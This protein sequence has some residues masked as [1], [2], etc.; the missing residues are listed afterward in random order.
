MSSKSGALGPLWMVLVLILVLV[1]PVQAQPGARQD[2]TLNLVAGSV[3]VFQS[4]RDGNWELYSAN[5][6]GSNLTR[7]TNQNAADTYPRFNHGATR[8]A[9]A[10]RGVANPDIFLVNPDGTGVTQLTTN[11]ADDIMPA[12]TFDGQQ[13]AF[14]SKRNDDYEVYK[15][16]NDGANQ[17][18]LTQ[19]PG[20]DIWPSWSPDATRLVFASNR[21]GD[22]RIWVMN[23][24]GSGQTQLSNQAK[25]NRPAWSPDGAQVA[26]DADG[27][28]DGFQEVWLMN[29]D[30]SNQ[31]QLY[32]PGAGADAQ[33]SGWSPDSY[34]VAYTRVEYQGGNPSAAYL[35]AV[36]VSSGTTVRLVS[37]NQDW[38]MDWQTTDLIPPTSSVD[39]L[40]AV[41]T[42]PFTVGWSMFDT[43][44]AGLRNCD[45]QVKDGAAGAWT[46]WL[47]QATG[48]SSSYPGVGGHTYYFRSRC[49]DN[50]FNLEQY[51]ADAQAVTTV[52]KSAPTSK[53]A[54][55]PAYYR[56]NQ[57]PV[58][59][60]GVDL[61]NSG[62]KS[63]DVQVKEDAG[64]WTNW[65]VGTTETTATYTGTPGH[66]YSFRGRATDNAF[67]VEEWP[68]NP[69]GDT[70][71]TLYAWSIAGNAF[72][73]RDTPLDGVTAGTDPAAFQSRP[74]DDAG[75]Y[76]SYVETVTAA[77]TVT[78]DKAGYG[79]LP[80][81]ELDANQDA[82]MDVILPPADN[83]VV[84]CGFETGSLDPA[85]TTGGLI[86]PSISP[87]R[88]DT[89]QYGALLGCQGP[90]FG[91]A[92]NVSN[93]AATSHSPRLALDGLGK[94]HAAWVETSGESSDVWYAL[95]DGSGT[96]SAPYQLTTSGNVIGDADIAA[97]SAG[98]AYVVWAENGAGSEIY[99]AE[100]ATDGSWSAPRNVSN[101]ATGESTGPRVASAGGVV[102][103]I[104]QDTVIGNTEIYYAR[105]SSGI[106]NPSFDISSR[107]GDSQE[108]Q[109]ALASGG[110]LHVVWTEVS[111]TGEVYY[112]SCSSGSCA[113]P[114]NLSNNATDS[115]SP[116]VATSGTN[117]HVVWQDEPGIYYRM[118]S[119]TSWSA[120]REI[121]GMSVAAGTPRVAA[122][123]TGIVHVV[124]SDASGDEAL[125]S[126]ILYARK[127]AAGVWTT[128]VDISNSAGEA[129]APRLAVS[130]SGAVHVVWN[131][132]T[133]QSEVY[134]ARGES[135]GFWSQ[136]QQISSGSGSAQ[137]ARLVAEASRTVHV[138]WEDGSA[139]AGDILYSYAIPNEATGDS[140]IRQTVSIPAEMFAPTLSFLYQ[141]EG[142]SPTSGS[143][144]DVLV[145]D[146]SNTTAVFTST[147]GTLGWAHQWVDLGAWSGQTVDLIFSIHQTADRLCTWGYLDE[148][149]LGS[150]YP[151]LAISKSGPWKVLPGETVVY[152]IVYENRGGV[153]AAGVQVTDTL[154]AELTFV[155]ATPAPNA[156]SPALRWDVGDV[157]AR[158]GP[159]TI[160]VTATLS[161]DAAMN[162]ELTNAVLITAASPELRTDNNQATLGTLIGYQVYLP[163]V[164]KTFVK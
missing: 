88:F 21:T 60:S 94:L 25:S 27:D 83:V 105:R 1:L 127:S 103:V 66:S 100:R 119:G 85:W 132:E 154:P 3:I 123:S 39:P 19:D 23:G 92:E 76:Q 162:R 74:S 90:A 148:I 67:N 42:G 129:T 120:A 56:G 44:P 159:Q 112:T 133:T 136:P 33:V 122:E 75:F 107:S 126:E 149:S 68:S 106:W 53:V 157:A 130:G 24:D 48:N 138:A 80:E 102:H 59:W 97:D 161:A 78:W 62:I 17:L 14:V 158:S 163:I 121:S 124:W 4:Y 82:L 96:W 155:G 111:G 57:A 36:Q 116:Q 141:L 46:D 29:A 8:V 164:M 134:Y 86:L 13:I 12:W 143:S 153:T 135:D 77:Y 84:N 41:S 152:T 10:S 47:L 128:P 18:R 108:P 16:D 160:V 81:T 37:T 71:V 101:T 125:G 11:L 38:Y 28:G 93:S 117:V 114:E 151:D 69:D 58:S 95:R 79:D 113:S 26:Y 22:H 156:T 98:I 104:W 137:G 118:R 89:G 144:L 73:N 150:S 145:D 7:L 2:S 45:I 109:L 31:H 115:T 147:S 65:L 6:D 20:E 51:P 139:G 34:Y 64:S 140:W 55:L 146:G 99:Y 30:G 70:T 35:E 32:D 40:P 110:A 50:G 54:M 61:G 63:Y 142:A 5:D 131:N 72:D 52:E 43:G 15:M 9:Y 49:R 87:E 91:P